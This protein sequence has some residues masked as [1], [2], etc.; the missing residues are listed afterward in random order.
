VKRQRGYYA[1]PLL[2]RDQV[3]GWSN[4]SV[5]NGELQAD[6]GYIGARP[7]RDRAFTHELEA[8][9]DR[10]RTFLGLQP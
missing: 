6:F 2:W 10:M 7:P 3:I 1:L 4:V 9:L 5:K 8:E